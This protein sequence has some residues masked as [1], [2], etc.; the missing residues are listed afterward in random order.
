MARFK[1]IV[2]LA[3]NQNT[4]RGDAIE[5]CRKLSAEAIQDFR[6]TGVAQ[7]QYGAVVVFPVAREIHLCEF[8]SQDFQPELKADH[9]RL[10]YVTMGSSQH[11]TD[12]FLAFLRDIFWRESQPTVKQATF[13]V[14]W[15][16]EHAIKVNPGGVNGPPRLAMVQ[17]LGEVEARLLTEAELDEHREAIELAR[18]GLRSVLQTLGGPAP[19]TPDVPRR[20][21]TKHNG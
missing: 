18:Q 6:S 17:R 2:D 14:L 20:P 21:P 3:W 8:A 19:T 4:F 9:P 10:W 11:I 15:T 12:P 1:R 7:G 16:L 5:V 13:A